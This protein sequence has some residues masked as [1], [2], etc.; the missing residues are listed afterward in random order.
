M[1]KNGLWKTVVMSMGIAALLAGCSTCP[2]CERG[3]PAPVGE[4]IFGVP[5]SPGAETSYDLMTRGWERHWPYGP[6]IA[7]PMLW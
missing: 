2:T 3:R 5:S 1:K 4:R 7:A 6:N